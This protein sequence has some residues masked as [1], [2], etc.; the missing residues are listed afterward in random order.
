[1]R[2][3]RRWFACHPKCRLASIYSFKLLPSAWQ[4]KDTVFPLILVFGGFVFFPGDFLFLC[5]GEQSM[6]PPLS[7]TVMVLNI[8]FH[9]SA[10]KLSRSSTWPHLTQMLQLLPSVLVKG[11]GQQPETWMAVCFHGS[12]VWVATSALAR[13]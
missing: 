8:F 5:Q 7:D 2:W 12:S 11:S 13:T 4:G 9:S 1:M 3:A 10:T 6:I